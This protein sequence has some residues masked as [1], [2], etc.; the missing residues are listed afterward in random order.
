M[1][2]QLTE[3]SYTFQIYENVTS[4]YEIG[5]I[6]YEDDTGMHIHSVIHYYAM[7]LL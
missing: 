7:Y 3:D 4:D 5:F 2:P 6:T 1:A